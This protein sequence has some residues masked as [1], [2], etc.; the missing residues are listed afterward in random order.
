MLGK[1]ERA[2]DQRDIGGRQVVTKM[3]G[4]FGDFRHAWVTRGFRRQLNVCG[5]SRSSMPTLPAAISRSAMTVGLSRS[6]S[7]SGCE[8]ALIWRARLVA[9]SVSSKRLGILASAS[10][11]VIRAMVHPFKSVARAACDAG[12][13]AGRHADETPAQLRA[14]LRPQKQTPD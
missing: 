12:C 4:E 9:A 11:I 3:A 1:R 14:G 10:S 13:A 2:L 5:L 6:G 8:P 7:R